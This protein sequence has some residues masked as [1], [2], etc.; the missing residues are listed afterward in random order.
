MFVGELM[1][2]FVLGVYLEVRLPITEFAYIQPQF[3]SVVFESSSYSTS[4]S[5]VVYFLLSSV[6]ILYN[7]KKEKKSQPTEKSIF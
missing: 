7:R 2:M 5:T 1:N 3:L 4:L 6:L